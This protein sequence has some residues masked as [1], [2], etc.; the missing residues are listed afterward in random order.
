VGI[1]KIKA[2]GKEKALKLI[3][4]QLEAMPVLRK[5]SADSM[6]FK[7]WKQTTGLYVE[8]VFGNDSRNAKI[9]EE[10]SFWPSVWYSGMDEV[11][12]NR[13]SFESGLNESEVLLKRFVQELELFEDSDAS[14]APSRATGKSQRHWVGKVFV[15][16]GHDEKLKSQVARFLEQLDLQPIILHE[17]AD[18]GQTII[19]KF[20][21][22]SDV[23]FAVVLLTPD[24]VGGKLN[25]KSSSQRLKWLGPETE[26][27]AS[28]KSRARQNV[29]F[30]FGYFLGKL[31]RS[32]VCGLY[33]EGVELPSDY[34]GVLYTKVDPEG[35]WQFKLMKEL[36]AAG[37]DV[38]ANRIT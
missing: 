30:E 16:H 11:K 5:Q 35:A 34:S 22:H 15:V 17:Q 36:K 24:D 8:K 32:N 4:Q 12:S 31:G 28:L 19:E 10:L 13:E 37:L 14:V 2:I 9:F 33:C 3:G 7:T 38:D 1:D 18:Q 27:K 25:G 23:S 29:I 26:G 20:E 6:E 21:K